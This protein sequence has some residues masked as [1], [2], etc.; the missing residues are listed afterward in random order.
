M[1]LRCIIERADWLDC[2][3]ADANH[4]VQKVVQTV[5]ADQLQCIVNAFIGNVYTFATHPYS[6]R[7]LQ[8]ILENCPER[9]TRS[10]LD[11]LQQYAQLLMQDQY[12]NYVIQYIIEKGLPQDKSSVITQTFGQVLH[13]SKHKF[14][15][16]GRGLPQCLHDASSNALFCHDSG[17]EMHYA[18]QRVRAAY[19]SNGG[20]HAS[21]GRHYGRNIHVK[22]RGMLRIFLTVLIYL[23]SSTC[24]LLLFAVC[25]LPASTADQALERTTPSCHRR[26]GCFDVDHVPS[27]SSSLHSQAPYGCRKTALR[28]WRRHRSLPST[29]SASLR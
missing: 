21:C 27:E 19:H 15:S 7:V 4:V 22:T 10:L 17:R 29:I 8:R 20:T 16:N 13:L 2:P 5:P 12:G 26:A 11:E 28:P 3:Y 14:A 1:Y 25:Q 24:A 18:C 6:C 9:M 23:I